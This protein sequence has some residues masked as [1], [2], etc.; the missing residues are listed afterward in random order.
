MAIAPVVA[1]HIQNACPQTQAAVLRQVHLGG[2]G[3][4]LSKFEPQRL[5][6]QEIR[7]LPDGLYCVR[8]QMAVDLH[9][10]HRAD[11]EPAQIGH[12][13]PHAEHAAE[14]IADGHG[15]IRRDAP[16]DGELFRLIGDH[17]QAVRS[18]GFH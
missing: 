11:A 17:L 10:P 15:L 9:R 8:A 16:Q 1:Q 18:E 6:A 2:D 3:I 7:I 12:R 4:H 14:F 13:L 5:A